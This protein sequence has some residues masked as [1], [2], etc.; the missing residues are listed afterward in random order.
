MT[1]RD[2]SQLLVPRGE[3]M[4]WPTPSAAGYGR[5]SVNGERVS[6]HV[7]IWEA[8]NGRLPEGQYL[9]HTCHDDAAAHGLCQ[10]GRTCPHRA[11][12]LLEHI[13]PF[14]DDELAE[15]AQSAADRELAALQA[16]LHRPSLHTRLVLQ[17][18]QAYQ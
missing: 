9:R 11:C 16:E 10:G 3:C 8:A 15:Q 13:T 12:G 17:T 7:A 2:F 6:V 1:V 4:V 5:V 18:N 14:T